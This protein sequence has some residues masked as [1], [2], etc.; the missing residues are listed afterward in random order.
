M[1]KKRVLHGVEIFDAKVLIAGGKGAER[2]VEIFD[3][4]RN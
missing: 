1:K 3:I 4:T 2:D